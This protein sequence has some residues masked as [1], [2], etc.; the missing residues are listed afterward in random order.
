MS[1]PT[2]R[3][4]GVLALAVVSAASI[5]VAAPTATSA[6]PA[7]APA[8]GP[9]APPLPDNVTFASTPT[10]DAGGVFMVSRG[11]DANVLISRGT[12]TVA[13][14][15]NFQQLAT[16]AVGDPT[17]AIAPS[18]VQ[19]FWRTGG[20]D[21]ATVLASNGV[22]TPG[23]TPDLIDG[24]KISSEVAA[25]AIPSRGSLPPLIRIFARGQDDG[26][27]YTNLLEN[28]SA[29]GWVRLGGFTTSEI[30]ASVIGPTALTVNIR[31]VI[32]GGDNRLFSMVYNNTDG[33]V[34]DWSPLGD[35][36]ATGNPTLSVNRMA[37]LEMQG[38]QVAVLSQVGGSFSNSL[39]TWDFTNPGWVNLGGNL[40]GD[41]GVALQSDGGVNLYT[42]GTNNRVFVN[43]RPAGTSTFG[44]F[45]NLG[46]R[47]TSN[48]VASGGDFGLNRR[49]VI[50]QFITKSLDNRMSSRI[51]ETSGRYGGFFFFGGLL[52]G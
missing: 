44:G 41:V 35:L 10:I 31:L 46:G 30:A 6:A 51:L 12:P 52:H 37:P 49:P 8:A 17:A 38:N 36:V 28:G 29:T 20:N 45:L 47:A 43:R 42:R 22:P 19:V 39:N 15:D 24:L 23:V 27:V 50:D 5:A 3:A 11:A 33:V 34:S 32:R 2:R 13:G 26:A 16:G 25:V 1:R 21:V 9:V 18:G 40:V 7:S 14:F 4:A 48:V